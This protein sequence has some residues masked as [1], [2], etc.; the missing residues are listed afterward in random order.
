MKDIR[1]LKLSLRDFQ[2]ATFSLDTNGDD[3]SVFAANGAG[4][5]RLFSAFTFLLFGKDSLNRSDF[6]I[7]TLNADGD[8]ADHGL[9][10]TVEGVLEVDGEE[11]TLKKIYS[12]KFVKVRGRQN[13][14][15]SG[16]STQHFIDDIPKAEKDYKAYI[17][18]IAGDEQTFRLLTSPTA[19][20][21]LP[22]QKQRALLLEIFGDVSDADIIAS[23]PRLTDLPKILG[24]HKAEDYKKI[25]AARQSEL[26]KA[27]GSSKQPGTI[28]TRI[29]EVR[30]GLPELPAASR[31][32]LD[33]M[34]S[35]LEGTLNSAKL[36]LQGIDTG[37]KIA[38]LSKQ[39]AVISSD[40]QKI[41]SAHY[42]ETMKKVNKLDQDLAEIQGKVNRQ[43]KRLVDVATELVA[44]KKSLDS[45]ELQLEALRV[46]WAAIDAQEFQDTTEQICVAC[47]Q[48][49][50][51]ERVQDAKEKA[52]AAWNND[53]ADALARIEDN[54]QLLKVAADKLR[55]LIADLEKSSSEDREDFSPKIDKIIAE[56]DNLKMQAHNCDSPEYRSLIHQ[57]GEIETQINA[58]KT[59]RSADT[60]A[61]KAEITTLSVELN[62]AKADAQKY[63][64]REQGEKR[65]VDLLSEEKNLALESEKLLSELYLIDLFTTLKVS[66]LND[67]MS[68][69]FEIV[70]WKLAEIQVNGEVNDQMC[71]LTVGGI[72]YNSGLNSAAKIQGGMDII[73]MLQRHYKLVAVIWIDNRESC[74]DIPEMPCQIIS[75]VVSPP[76]AVLRVEKAKKTMGALFN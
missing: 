39:L 66:M 51:A 31:A 69:Q 18:E 28:E 64:N 52:L 37:G 71:E 4:K 22:W 65:I 49:L 40:L 27:L 5:T 8:V 61:I 43:T 74:T 57:R 15:F 53:K 35:R 38:D 7:K 41:E 42:S 23:D 33:G 67:K 11:V 2:G 16:H 68:G 3:I 75:L 34:I 47:G 25:V 24:R 50:P 30:R 21:L 10:H 20:P 62:T 32:K 76:D 36:K 29:D 12:E 48:S 17:Q 55:A 70:K 14:E 72:G 58:E 56:K 19:F 26:T 60:E 54:G 13:P 44:S 9:Q 63:V 6:S 45:S 59:G 1:L 46:K 73:K